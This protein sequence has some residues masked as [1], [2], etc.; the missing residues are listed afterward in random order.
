[1]KSKA[2]FKGGINKTPL[3]LM[4]LDKSF[5]PTYINPDPP[6]PGPWA[7]FRSSQGV[8]FRRP[9]LFVAFFNSIG[10]IGLMG[11]KE[12]EM[13]IEMKDDIKNGIVAISGLLALSLSFAMLGADL[14]VVLA[15]FL[16][17]AGVLL[18]SFGISGIISR[19]LQ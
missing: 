19:R 1:M 17:I 5:C 4:R 15:I 13:N 6:G 9:G 8:V 18:L 11:R 3:L 14:K 10:Y 2:F 12:I 7:R 16:I